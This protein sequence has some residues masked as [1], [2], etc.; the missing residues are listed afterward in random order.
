M[1]GVDKTVL[2][3][4]GVRDACRRTKL[5]VSVPGDAV[6]GVDGTAVFGEKK[7]GIILSRGTQQ[8][9]GQAPE[10]GGHRFALGYR[11]PDARFYRQDG[12]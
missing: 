11:A 6:S 2:E 1:P 4:L 9:L 12:L 3:G 5:H 7:K 10:I 8:V